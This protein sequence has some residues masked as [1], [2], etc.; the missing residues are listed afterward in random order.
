MKSLGRVLL[1]TSCL[2][3]FAHGQS[4][5]EA[6][7]V[8]VL[9][10]DSYGTILV[11]GEGQS[12]YAFDGDT[13]DT[14][15]CTADC[16]AAW[17]PATTTGDPSAGAGVAASL[18]GTITR[19]DGTT[20]L[21]YAS[22]PLY[23]FSE[24]Q[25]PGDTNGHGVNAFGGVW[26]L[27]SPY[28]SYVDVPEP[29]EQAEAADE[30]A[31]EPEQ[32]NIPTTRTELLELGETVYAANCAVCHGADGEGFTGPQLADN[33]NLRNTQYV[34]GQILA[35]SGGMPPFV[36]RLS[37]SEV[38]AVTTFIRG[39]WGNEFGTVTTEEVETLAH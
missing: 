38:A 3:A 29:V 6:V 8:Q 25:A 17:P 35:G 21:T 13:A 11:D 20:Q 28:G 1:V 39:S 26:Y 30:A 37:H 23:Y 36:G 27:V 7:T 14:G 22:N 16:L 19:D 2:F 32:T 4:D 31:P 9:N 15:N 33:G 24:D 10:H 5:N 18:L 34:V 12:L